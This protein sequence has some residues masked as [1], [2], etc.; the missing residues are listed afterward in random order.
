MGRVDGLIGLNAYMA[1]GGL[2]GI[3][4]PPPT[5]AL[6]LGVTSLWVPEMG[7]MAATGVGGGMLTG[8]TVQYF[9]PRIQQL[10]ADQR[11]GTDS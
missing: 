3:D 10:S 8:S 4:P 1:S 11:V 7:V 6:P 5:P 9:I 2:Q